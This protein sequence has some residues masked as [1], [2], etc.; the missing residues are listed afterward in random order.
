MIKDDYKQAMTFPGGI[1]D[2]SEGAK[3]AALRETKEEAGLDIAPE[4]ATFFSVC[5]MGERHG[6]KDCFHFFFIV[7]VDEETASQVKTEDSI[8]YHKWVNPHEIAALAGDR[9]LYN[10][11]QRILV[12]GE[13]VPYFEC[14]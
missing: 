7:D 1:I 12:S 8:E 10:E 3:D 6:F 4:S 2:P 14:K 9:E 11:L 13:A 5:Y